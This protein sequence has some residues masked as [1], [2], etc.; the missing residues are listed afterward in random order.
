LNAE[1]FEITVSRATWAVEQNL[2]SKNENQ[3]KAAGLMS[4]TVILLRRPK[5]CVS[6][7]QV[8]AL[9]AGLYRVASKIT[10]AT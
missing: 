7:S 10:K 4:I 1:T 5:S 6:W 9:P 3:T 2:V 8:Q